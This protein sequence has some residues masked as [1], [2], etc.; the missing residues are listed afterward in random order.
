MGSMDMGV[1]REM[2]TPDFEQLVFPEVDHA[3][4]LDYAKKELPILTEIN[5]VLTECMDELRD[6]LPQGIV[7]S[8]FQR[9]KKTEVKNR[10]FES[11]LMGQAV[12]RLI[13]EVA[14]VGAG[15]SSV[16]SYQSTRQ[17]NLLLYRSLGLE[18]LYGT[19]KEANELRGSINDSD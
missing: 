15:E 1:V 18:S 4:N 10:I 9:S 2:V 16:E 13:G 14:R 7:A 3:A 6:E 19:I 8:I 17:F 12:E 5:D 11:R